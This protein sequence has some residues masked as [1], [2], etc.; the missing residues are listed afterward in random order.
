MCMKLTRNFVIAEISISMENLTRLKKEMTLADGRMDVGS[1][2]MP[3]WKSILI[4]D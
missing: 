2:N 4:T 1:V 3:F